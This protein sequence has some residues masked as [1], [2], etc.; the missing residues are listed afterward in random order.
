MS[1]FDDCVSDRTTSVLS[2]ETKSFT[3]KYDGM[4]L[5][6]S[7]QTKIR[8]GSKPVKFNDTGHSKTWLKMIFLPF[9]PRLTVLT[10]T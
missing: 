10:E 8:F 5:E 2:G 7:C 1:F 4:T 6:V 9:P 3:V